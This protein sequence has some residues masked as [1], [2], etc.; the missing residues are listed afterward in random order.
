MGKKQSSH[1]NIAIL[2][3]LHGHITLAYC[4]LMR[5]EKEHGEKIDLILQVGDIGV[6]PFPERADKTTKRFA[7]KDPAELSF[8]DYYY[9]F[10]KGDE[11]LGSSNDGSGSLNADMY[12]IKGNHDD[13]EFLD[14]MSHGC[15]YPVTVDHYAKMHYMRSGLI[16]GI[17][18]RNI[19]LNVGA[20][21][22][23]ST[24]DGHPGKDPRSQF[25]TRAEVRELRAAGNE[26]DIFLSHQAPLGT[27]N[28]SGGSIDVL[29]F[30]DLY[31]PR[32]HFCGHHLVD[33]QELTVPGG[34][35]SY[36]M[37]H[38]NFRSGKLLNPG[39]V[40]ILRWT[41]H[42]NNE[43]HFLDEPW[44]KDFSRSSYRCL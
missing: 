37:S 44:M 35:K 20:L 43:F 40:G 21:G 34:T 29:D 12:F 10:P 6:Y 1:A 8:Q 36:I 22:G 4:L 23:V 25:Y 32:Y 19:R 16:T 2:G 24:R 38:V 7:K 18:V 13:F 14:E 15:N 11:I 33:G 30:I 26:L 41:D 39:C 3:D 17:Y 42:D 27:L 28:E 31:E 9:G 5:W